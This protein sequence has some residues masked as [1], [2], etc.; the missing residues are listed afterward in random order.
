MKNIAWTR[1]LT[2]TLL[3][4][5]A[6]LAP[7]TVMA[8]YQPV[9]LAL[10][11]GADETELNFAWISPESSAGECSIE[12]SADAQKSKTFSASTQQADDTNANYYYCKVTIEGLSNDSEYSYR[13]GDNKGG[14]SDSYSYSTEDKDEY[15]F[16]Y[17]ADAQIGSGRSE[18]QIKGGYTG[19][20][21]TVDLIYTH[22]PDSAFILSAGDQIE[23]P[24]SEEEWNG[25]FAP[26]QNESPLPVAPVPAAHDQIQF[27]KVSEA[28]SFHFNLPNESEHY[29]TSIDVNG[30]DAPW[31]RGAEC[32]AKYQD[33]ELVGDYSFTYG[34][35]LYIGL[36]MDSKDYTVHS[37]YVADA[38]AANPDTKWRIVTWHYTIYS[39]A[40]QSRR[41][42]EVDRDELASIMEKNQID[43]VLMGHD[44][45]YCRTY[46]LR[47]GKV[48]AETLNDK[49][50]SIN[51]NGVVYY[52][53]NSASGSKY[54]P[55][56]NEVATLEYAAAY[57]QPNIPMFSYVTVDQD[58]LKID[59]YRTDNMEIVD[60]Y[61][62]QKIANK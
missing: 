47:G 45:T 5:L 20:I 44:H 40:D 15:G 58:S 59:T 50:E 42:T 49:G 22:F 17:L 3:T 61:A 53:A 35:V 39:A 31:N 41:R 62:I 1:K 23:N 11:P 10:T 54:Y 13:I 14:W 32:E 16:I 29:T 18:E 43:V 27:G 7:L 57:A 46:P 55:M 51:P 4:T 21:K 28:T 52:T 38:I 60:S 56:S 34:D 36:D 26:L 33:A 48:Q 24:G 8:G 12:L 6:V 19:W 37:K 2:T 9:D 30:C 25:F